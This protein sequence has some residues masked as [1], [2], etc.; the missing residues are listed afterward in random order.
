MATSFCC[1]LGVQYWRIY[2]LSSKNGRHHA[3]AL[4]GYPEYP[5]LTKFCLLHSLATYCGMAWLYGQLQPFNIALPL[6]P[7]NW[8]CLASGRYQ[9]NNTVCH[10]KVSRSDEGERRLALLH[11]ASITSKVRLTVP[12]NSMP[13]TEALCRTLPRLLRASIGMT[14]MGEARLSKLRAN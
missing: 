13:P 11:C 2:W 10:G 3:N 12:F 7:N 5:Q 9:T 8:L 1:I 6:L 14:K 4:L